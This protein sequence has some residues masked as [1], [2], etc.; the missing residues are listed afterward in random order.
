MRP[1]AV[2]DASTATQRGDARN[3]NIDGNRPARVSALLKDLMRYVELLRSLARRG[4]ACRPEWVRV[5]AV[6][7]VKR[8]GGETQ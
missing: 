3:T 8:A 6:G 7:C 1:E 2:T 4:Q 5:W